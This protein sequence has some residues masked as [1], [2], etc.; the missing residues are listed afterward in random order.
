MV[1]LAV[2]YRDLNGQAG[3]VLGGGQAAEAG[4][5]NYDSRPGFGVHRSHYRDS[6]YGR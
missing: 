4:A 6:E 1:V 5:D 3:K 2:H